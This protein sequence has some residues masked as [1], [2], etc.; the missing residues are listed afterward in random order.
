MLRTWENRDIEDTT[1]L[2]LSPVDI[3]VYNLISDQKFISLIRIKTKRIITDMTTNKLA[4]Y[5]ELNRI[6][7]YEC[8]SDE[9]CTEET[10]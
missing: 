6:L 2:L 9:F 5:Q 1:H 8:N 4:R 7:R 3:V 10:D